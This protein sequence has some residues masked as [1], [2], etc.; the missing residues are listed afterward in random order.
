[1]SIKLLIHKMYNIGHFEG[2]FFV[3]PHQRIANARDHLQLLFES[4]RVRRDSV[5]GLVN[6][7]AFDHMPPPFYTQNGGAD[8]SF[9]FFPFQLPPHIAIDATKG[10]EVARQRALTAFGT[11]S[12]IL[13][14]QVRNTVFKHRPY[15]EFTWKILLT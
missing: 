7:C 12:A 10:I 13:L 1:M 8:Y 11:T 14:T 5:F 4:K 2:G 9:S 3:R 15:L 6:Q